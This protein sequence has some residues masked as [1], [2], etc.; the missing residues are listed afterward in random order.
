[1][2]K[3]VKINRLKWAGHL[4]RM[5]EDR[6]VRKVCTAIPDGKRAKGRPKTRWKDS[7]I[8]LDKASYGYKQMEGASEED[9]GPYGLSC[10]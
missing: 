2:V 7:C 9:Q 10:Q 1:M 8:K 6:I 5:S 3:Y 4:Q